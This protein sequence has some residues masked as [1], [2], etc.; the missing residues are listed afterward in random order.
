MQLIVW[1]LY[2]IRACPIIPG[3]HCRTLRGRYRVWEQFINPERLLPFVNRFDSDSG[4]GTEHK[5]PTFA[6]DED[7]YDSKH[8]SGPLIVDH[9]NKICNKME[10]V[11]DEEVSDMNAAQKHI[12]HTEI[13]LNSEMR[14]EC[15]QIGKQIIQFNEYLECRAVIWDQ[16]ISFARVKP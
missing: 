16:S 8:I 15:T 10:N 7:E 9:S 3:K 6:M 5:S 11:L 4:S 14:I 13:D 1:I 2:L 12:L